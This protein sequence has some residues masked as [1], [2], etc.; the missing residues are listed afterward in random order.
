MESNIDLSSRERNKESIS[1]LQKDEIEQRYKSCLFAQMRWRFVQ[2]L[3]ALIIMCF[4]FR[5]MFENEKKVNV[6]HFCLVAVSGM[7]FV[8]SR[9]KNK[10]YT[11][12]A[13]KYQKDLER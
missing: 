3:S 9:H 11:E 13:L 10:R 2:V 7:G 8:V 12:E 5:Y 1:S 4:C 6:S